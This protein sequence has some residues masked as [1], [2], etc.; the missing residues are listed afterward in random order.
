[1]YATG[2]GVKTDLDAALRWYSAAGRQGDVAA[3]GQ[4]PI[5]WSL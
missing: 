4:A 1:M 3:Q 5:D 2:L